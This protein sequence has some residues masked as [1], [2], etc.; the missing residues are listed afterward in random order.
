MNGPLWN[1]THHMLQPRGL[2]AVVL[3]GT[4][5][6][7]AAGCS[8]ST[9]STGAA[10]SR[11][12]SS[13]DAR[14]SAPTPALELDSLDGGD[15]AVQLDANTLAA[16]TSLTVT[17]TPT[18]KAKATTTYQPATFDFPITGGN[19]KVFTKGEVDPYVQG[20]IHHDGSGLMF[21]AGG[22]TLTV[23]NF[24]A[25]P[26]TSMLMASVKGSTGKI[27]LF[28]LDGSGLQITKDAAGHAK[29]D[30]TKVELTAQAAAALNKTFSVT[31]FQPRLLVGSAHIAIR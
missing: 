19:V 29:L 2:G 14:S 20:I 6:L 21:A 12:S 30:G 7:A 4:V 3:L 5:A 23:E 25:D 9:P 22:K 18:G 8:T 26:G 10:T 11:L 28:F 24:D 16:L 31:A 15:T 17:V 13:A 27:P 1:R